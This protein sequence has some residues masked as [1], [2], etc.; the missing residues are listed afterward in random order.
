MAKYSVH[1][2]NFLRSYSLVERETLVDERHECVIA[3]GSV[4]FIC[5][6]V[7]LSLSVSLS[8]LSLSLSLSHTH[9]REHWKH[10][11]VWF[12]LKHNQEKNKRIC[13]QWWT[14]EMI[15]SHMI[16][17]SNMFSASRRF[18]NRTLKASESG[19]L[20]T[21]HSAHGRWMRIDATLYPADTEQPW[22]SDVGPL[23]ETALLFCR[24]CS[25]LGLETK[26]LHNSA[27]GPLSFFS[28]TCVITL[29]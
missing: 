15:L 2:F 26:K 3:F 7:C 19:Q 5:L 22:E 16:R 28:V 6:F 11:S 27:W 9:T 20:T 23:F 14:V 18:C 24:C 29:S 25:V 10:C 1:I 12:F 13:F 17:P 8:C 4:L 21:S